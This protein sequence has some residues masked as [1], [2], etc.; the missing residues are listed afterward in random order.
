MNKTAFFSKTSPAQDIR[1]IK[2]HSKRTFIW[3]FYFV[4]VVG[5]SSASK[6]PAQ[7]LT[8]AE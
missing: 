3:Y 6:P 1:L 7:T 2:R 4:N 5:D 8:T